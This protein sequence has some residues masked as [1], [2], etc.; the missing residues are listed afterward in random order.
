MVFEV[1]RPDIVR[2]VHQR[3]LLNFWA[4]QLQGRPVP[5]W[6]TIKVDSLSGMTANL[7]LLDVIGGDGGLRFAIRYHGAVVGQVY[8]SADCRGRYLDEVLPPHAVANALMPYRQVV[9]HGRP[10]Y[11]INEVTDS[12]GRPVHYERLLLPFAHDGKSVDR[13]LASLEF[14]CADGAYDLKA[15][16]CSQH[17]PPAPRLS[18]TIEASTL[19]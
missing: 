2:A 4:Q 7:S 15:L 12:N 6:Q 13:I 16:M 5:Q 11:T 18:A 3:W 8:G 14:F 10:I 9:E 19:P 17:K 1:A